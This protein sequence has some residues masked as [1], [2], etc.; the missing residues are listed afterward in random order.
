MHETKSQLSRG[1]AGV[2]GRHFS[3]GSLSISSDSSPDAAAHR[4]TASLR[5]SVPPS[6]A[7]S[8]IDQLSRRSVSS[9]AGQG[10]T[11]GIWRVF[12][13]ENRSD[14]RQE[15]FNDGRE[16]GVGGENIFI[17][18]LCAR[19]PFYGYNNSG[20]KERESV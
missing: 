7:A 5:P 4:G 8:K 12:V 20:V 6:S 18:S 3:G 14:E 11:P 9:R 16:G 10:R 13:S 2:P 19:V 17:H 1:A 15:R